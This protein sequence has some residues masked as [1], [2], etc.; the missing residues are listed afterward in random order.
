MAKKYGLLLLILM[1]SACGG[2]GGM[3]VVVAGSTSV[4]PYAELLAEEF[5]ARYPHEYVDVQGGG[6]SAGI[7]AAGSGT[8]DIGM[9][10]RELTESE[11]SM[12]HVEIARDGLAIIIH[13]HNPVTNLTLAQIQDI[14][15]GTV[16]NW[17]HYGGEDHRIHVAARE[18]GS[19]TRSAFDSLVMEDI[20]I[21]PRAI[22]QDSNG[23]V[24]QF[25]G[26]DRYSIGFISL[27]LVDDTVKP[28]QINGVTASWENVRNGLYNLF[29][30]F[31]FVSRAQPEGEAK[32]FV[33][34]TLSEAGQEI[35]IIEGLIPSGPVSNGG[36]GP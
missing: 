27:G 29:R 26:N 19:G 2:R 33:D 35:M 9:S 20:R 21:T 34:F 4:Q 22:I 17:N 14:Y 15:T 11:L 25:V 5:S 18:E 32:R 36:E 16:T 6:S 12:W 8:A 23:A 28:I 24:R 7:T 3:A 13:P 10:S 1:L 31:I 30:P